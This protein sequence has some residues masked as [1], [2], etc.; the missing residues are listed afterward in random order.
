MLLLA[1]LTY[2]SLTAITFCNRQNAKTVWHSTEQV[3][4]K[5]CNTGSST[6]LKGQDSNVFQQLPYCLVV[7]WKAIIVRVASRLCV[8]VLLSYPHTPNKHL[9]DLRQETKPSRSAASFTTLMYEKAIVHGCLY[10]KTFFFS[11]CLSSSLESKSMNSVALLLLLPHRAVEGG[12]DHIWTLLLSLDTHFRSQNQAVCGVGHL[13]VREGHST[14]KPDAQLL[15]HFLKLYFQVLTSL[16][17]SC[18]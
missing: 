16:I 7:L 15:P 2:G 5:R 18:W 17:T 10:W 3:D 11:L 13:C 6:P 12:S 14:S 4:L 9:H 1:K 8:M